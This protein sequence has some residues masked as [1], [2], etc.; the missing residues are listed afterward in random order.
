MKLQQ[1]FIIKGQNIQQNLII[2][3]YSTKDTFDLNNLNMGNNYELCE[4][5]RSTITFS[6]EQGKTNH[7]IYV[8]I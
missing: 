8:I 1:L 3:K 2:F 5:T 4:T 7:N 6:E